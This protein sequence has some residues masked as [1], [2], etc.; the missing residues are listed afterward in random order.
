MNKHI[1]EK[2]AITNIKKSGKLFLPY[3]ITIT[4]SMMFYYILTS[5]GSNP[6]IYNVETGKQ[7][8]KGASTLC[9]ILQSGSFVA[10]AFAFIFL[11]YANSFVFKHQKKQL[12]LYRVLGME[13]KHIV[14]VVSTET[15]LIFFAGLITSLI[16]GI[17]FDKLML[18]FLFKIIN[19]PAYTGFFISIQAV[20]STVCLTAAIALFVLL[21]N[22][23]SVFFT[24]D[25]ELLKSEKTGEKEPKDRKILALS[26]ILSL[27]VGYWI[28]LDTQNVAS[29]ISNFFPAAI[30]VI[31]ATY[32]LFTAGSIAVLKFLKKNKSYYYTPK[33][34]ISVSGMLYRMKQNAAG[35]ATIC[36]LSTA[37][38]IVI[39]AG[40][41]LYANG[42]YSI[43]QQFP[44]MVQ[45]ASD[46]KDAD[47]LKEIIDITAK[48]GNISLQNMVS[49]SYGTSLYEFDGKN[50]KISE[51]FS[52]TDFEHTPDT[53]ILTLEEYN[54]FNHTSETLEENQILLYTTGSLFEGNTL[55]YEDVSY[56]VKA[57][58]DKSCLTYIT[59]TSMVLFPKLLIVVPNKEVFNSF[60]PKKNEL[61]YTNF[62]LG[63]NMDL[64]E[65]DIEK[66][67]NC[68]SKNLDDASIVYDFALKHVEK[69]EFFNMYG[70]L[71]F[72]GMILG[73]LFLIS[74]V[75]I[76]Y[77]KQ[78]SEGYDDRERYLIMQKIG[79]SKEEI[80]QS[81]H[82]Q[83][84]L[85]FFLP[86][87]TAIIHSCVALPI[88][89]KCLSLALVVN[90]PTFVL[91]VV[92]TC[93]AFSVVYV[94][95]YKV[96]SRAYYKIVNE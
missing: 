74:T 70:G 40:A 15:L 43:N 85:V 1:Y 39:S 79:L 80:L 7:C 61:A 58:A 76:I 49:C 27:S 87:V 83:V 16:L 77:Y 54:R 19:Q 3:L 66:F 42:N 93:I 60:V 91:S 78:I 45:F 44:R 11:L 69:G 84:M 33:H 32:G 50:L 48:N 89:S 17:L 47:D 67:G 36:I 73:I 94:V 35:L 14:R 88:V 56:Q 10:A 72:V 62:Y 24:K 63:F 37:T 5:I 52:F 20:K 81:I 57:E 59:D 13:R 95:V 64:L 46:T 23:I 41:S 82:S 75:M 26:G 6:H 9:G 4:G 92:G 34:F 31:L 2:M 96:T 12:G 38:I 65:E 30:L 51:T 71:F 28:A 55:T 86:L 68:I 8:F 29:A 53:F 25:I 18:V 90:M 22:L 21:G